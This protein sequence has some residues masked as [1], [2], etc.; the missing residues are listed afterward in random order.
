MK[1]T[2]IRHGKPDTKYS[3]L[4]TWREFQAWLRH[5]ETAKL[6]EKP[7][8][9]SASGAKVLT[10]TLPRAIE[11][12]RAL[13]PRADIETFAI[14]DSVPVPV[15]PIPLVKWPL[16]RWIHLNRCLYQ[17]SFPASEEWL[18]DTRKRARKAAKFLEDW[19]KEFGEVIL[20]GHGCMNALIAKNL[21]RAG[22]TGSRPKKVDY[23]GAL[24]LEF[25]T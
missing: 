14:F 3:G 19:A 20:V 1:I 23:L 15:F 7:S 10:S 11:T 25:T 21:L 16:Q 6:K 5:Y 17:L 12:A 2:L 18:W 4:F 22:W 13:Y 9:V 8:P 24:T